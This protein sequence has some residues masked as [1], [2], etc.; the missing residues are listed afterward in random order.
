MTTDFSLVLCT[1]NR[2]HEVDTFLASIDTFN[3]NIEVIL[4][5]QN[6]DGRLDF[7]I[8]KFEHLNLRHFKVSFTGLS[9]ARNYGM[10]YITGKYVAFPDD[11]CLYTPHLLQS[12]VTFF[13]NSAQFGFISARTVDFYDQ[14]KSLVNATNKPFEILM[15]RRAGCSFTYFFKNNNKFKLLG[16]DEL[17]GVGA[18]TNYGAGEETDFITNALYHGIR[19]YYLPNL[20]IYHECKEAEYNKV[21]LDRLTSYSGGYAYHIRKNYKKLG[22]LYSLK[23]VLAIPSRVFKNIG[24]K[25]E[26]IKSLYFLK[27]SLK[28]FFN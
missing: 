13:E 2:V 7:L 28:G 26:L 22:F 12:I 10:K 21:V 3:L 5:D 15:G 18:K 16:F 19:G 11:D 14:S 17:M 23:L 25:E 9:R 24:N 8:N 27:G 1:L 20:T 4:V 6:Q